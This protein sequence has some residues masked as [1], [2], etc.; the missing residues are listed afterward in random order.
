[1]NDIIGYNLKAIRI[2]RGWPQSLVSRLTG[3]SIRSISRIENGCSASKNTIKKLCYFYKV[4][5]DSLYNPVEPIKETKVELISDS[6]LICIMRQN[7]LLGDLQRE[8]LLSLTSQIEKTVVMDRNDIE[9]ILS[10]ALTEKKNYT[11]SDIITACM[12][13]N[14]KT[15]QNI[16]NMAIA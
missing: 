4:D 15:I 7:S 8:M 6:Q 16:T 10:E 2:R 9:A 13:V 12:A 5:M 11:L 1:M 14:Q 3:I